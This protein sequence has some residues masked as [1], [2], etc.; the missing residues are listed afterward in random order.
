MYP[1]ICPVT[2]HSINACQ[3]WLENVRSSINRGAK[4]MDHTIMNAA[5]INPNTI[6]FF[7]L[8]YYKCCN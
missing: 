5:N 4:S 6:N 2:G 1:T 3:G 8:F 7:I